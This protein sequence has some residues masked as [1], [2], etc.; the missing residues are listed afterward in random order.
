MENHPLPENWMVLRFARPMAW[1]E[2]CSTLRTSCADAVAVIMR[3]ASAIRMLARR[4]IR[5]SSVW[6]F[7]SNLDLEAFDQLGD[8]HKRTASARVVQLGCHAMPCLTR[9]QRAGARSETCKP[10]AFWSRCTQAL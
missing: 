1:A 9:C 3:H 5:S 7:C 4:V 8:F 6:C 2:A 10:L